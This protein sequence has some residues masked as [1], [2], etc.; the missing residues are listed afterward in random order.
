ML[1]TRAYTGVSVSIIIDVQHCG[2]SIPIEV[3]DPI[4]TIKVLILFSCRRSPEAACIHLGY[5]PL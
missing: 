2:L 4:S 5:L 3:S 1:S